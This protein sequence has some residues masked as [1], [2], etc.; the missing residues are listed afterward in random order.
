MLEKEEL[1]YLSAHLEFWDRLSEEQKEL[2]RQNTVKVTYP[3]GY[4]LYNTV[5]ECLGV[6][7]IQRGNLRVYLLSEDGREVTLYWHGAGEECVLSASCILNNASFDMH[8]DAESETTALL[9]PSCTFARLKEQNIYA[10][11]FLYRQS[12]ERFPD[13]IWAME[14]VLF[15]SLDKRLAI[16]LVDE[17]ART[18]TEKLHVTQEQIARYIGSAREV[19]SRTLKTFQADGLIEQSRGS[20]HVLD[21]K[22]LMELIY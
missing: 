4:N 19:V 21:K 10:E 3:K 14:Q 15:M 7:L 1:V 16:F 18:H 22:R 20:I 12:A 8:I 9:I 5:D 11:N 6:L 2:L 17:M 13:V